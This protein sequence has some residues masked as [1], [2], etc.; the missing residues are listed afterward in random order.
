MSFCLQTFQKTML[1]LHSRMLGTHPPLPRGAGTR[2]TIHKT[3]PNKIEKKNL[4]KKLNR[5]NSLIFIGVFSM[6][7]TEVFRG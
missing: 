2:G 1:D 5:R 7:I 3:R 6:E 4:K